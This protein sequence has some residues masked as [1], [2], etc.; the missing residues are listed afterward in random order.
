MRLID[1]YTLDFVDVIDV[2]TKPYAILSHTWRDGEEVSLQDWLKWR[3]KDPGWEEIAERSGLAKIL[4]ACDKTKEY[5]LNYIWIDTNCIDKLSSAE[6]SEAINSMFTWYFQSSICLAYLADVS[7]V[8]HK[9]TLYESMIRWELK[10]SRWFTRGWT[11]QELLAPQQM[12]FFASSWIKIGSK[13]SLSLMIQDITGIEEDYLQGSKNF[14]SASIASRMSWAALRQTSRAEDMAYSLLGIFDIN[15]PLLYGE[16]EKAF[17]RLQEEILKVSTDQSIFAWRFVERKNWTSFKPHPSWVSLLAPF[18]VCFLQSRSVV[19]PRAGHFQAATEV[20]S[21]TNLGLTMHLPLLATTSSRRFFAV[22]QCFDS[23]PACLCIPVIRV[24]DGLIRAAWPPGPLSLCAPNKQPNPVS[25]YVPRHHRHG[26]REDVWETPIFT[27]APGLIAFIT[28][29]MLNLDIR[30]WI[31]TPGAFLY[32]D[33]GFF[34]IKK[35]TKTSVT[36]GMLLGFKKT[37][38]GERFKAVIFNKSGWGYFTEEYTECHIN[39]HN[40]LPEVPVIPDIARRHYWWA[41]PFD[42]SAELEAS[43]RLDA[44]NELDACALILV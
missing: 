29:S 44:V 37:D 35:N 15:M 19:T 7:N 31:T 25:I 1:V 28:M 22:L 40:T 16:G 34:A 43:K 13:T 2:T 9:G 41:A 8:L 18:P 33:F 4:A 21:M 26:S 5:N 24:E 14:R 23:E 11:L 12:D 6:L 36:E 42:Y 38:D 20:W 32:S 30:G 39:M 27:E 3:A 10:D 17:I